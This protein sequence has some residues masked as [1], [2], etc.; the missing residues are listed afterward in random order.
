MN[1]FKGIE[2]KNEKKLK[3]KPLSQAQVKQMAQRSS[4]LSQNS[5]KSVVKNFARNGNRG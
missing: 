5:P 2:N 4:W 1:K 3:F